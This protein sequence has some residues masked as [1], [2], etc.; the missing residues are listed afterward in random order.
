MTNT[1]DNFD[2]AR[3][4]LYYIRDNCPSLVVAILARASY[5]ESFA[6]LRI[7]EH[8]LMDRQNPSSHNLAVYEIELD[9]GAF[10]VRV[11]DRN[12]MTDWNDG[13]PIYKYG[14]ELCIVFKFPHILDA[15]GTMGKYRQLITRNSRERSKVLYDGDYSLE[16]LLKC[17]PKLAKDL[18]KVIDED[19]PPSR[20]KQFYR[21]NDESFYDTQKIL[22]RNAIPLTFI[23]EIALR[24]PNMHPT[25]LETI[26]A[27]LSKNGLL[28]PRI[29]L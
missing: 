14:T 3:K 16:A 25:E 19:M 20:V 6:D 2:V 10:Q 29:K 4:S 12:R 26:R 23:Q 21:E 22:W 1:V 11:Y 15:N 17:I 5:A 8:N 27:I 7:S 24:C 9:V 13:K 28:R 18:V